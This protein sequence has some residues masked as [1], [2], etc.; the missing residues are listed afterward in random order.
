[1]QK[2]YYWY[3]CPVCRNPKM[4]KYRSDTVLRNFPGYCKYCK[5]ESLITLEPKSRIIESLKKI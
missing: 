2:R 4:L 1:M 5:T 3:K